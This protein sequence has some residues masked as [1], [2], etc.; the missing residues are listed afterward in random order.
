MVIEAIS[1]PERPLHKGKL[2]KLENG[3]TMTEKAGGRTT[4]LNVMTRAAGMM[5][6]ENENTGK[7]DIKFMKRRI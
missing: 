5:T 7:A 2:G 1:H 3:S 6:L 4:E